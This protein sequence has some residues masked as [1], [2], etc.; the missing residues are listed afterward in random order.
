MAALREQNVQIAA[1]SVGQQPARNGQTFTISVRAPGR[2]TDPAQFEDIIVKR[3][4]DGTLVRVQDIG[5][6]E[7]G[8]ESYAH[9]LALPGT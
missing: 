3:S 8:S 9:R 1:G 7:L 2:L 4:A 5:R 6:V